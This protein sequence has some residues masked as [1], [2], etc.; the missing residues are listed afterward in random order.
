MTLD[1][2]SCGQFQTR[3]VDVVVTLSEARRLSVKPQEVV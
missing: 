3:R 1:V 2:T